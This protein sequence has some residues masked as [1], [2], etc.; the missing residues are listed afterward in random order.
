MDELP[1][2]ANKGEWSELYVFFKI[3][4]DRVVYAADKN[5][6]PKTDEYYEFVKLFRFNSRKELLAYDLSNEDIVRVS[7]SDDQAVTVIS[8]DELGDKTRRILERIKVASST[9]S[10]EDAGGLM[11]TYRLTSVK[12]P[13]TSKADIDALVKTTGSPTARQMGFS[14]KSYIG[15]APTLVNS[16]SHTNFVYEVIGFSGDKDEVNSIDTRSKVRD[17]ISKIRDDGGKL[18]FSGMQSDTYRAN[19]RMQDSN[20]P[21]IMARMLQYFYEGNGYELDTLGGLVAKDL[22]LDTSYEE[23]RY[24]TKGFLRSSALGMVPAS[25]W[26]TRITTHGGYIVLFESGELLC[27]SLYYDDDFRD[28]LYSNTRFDTPS[29][30]KYDYGYLY[31][32]DGRLFIKLNLQVRFKKV[33][34]Y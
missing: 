1:R 5:L 24:K 28:Y 26:D 12:S 18:V 13:S 23:V 11:N 34:Q 4:L 16:S 6:Q 22:D 2:T 33:D 25:V 27:Y 31:E 17:R 10:V 15:G 20:Y 14:I 3:I 32:N 29:T 21:L 30:T 19:L 9:F 7:D 8:K